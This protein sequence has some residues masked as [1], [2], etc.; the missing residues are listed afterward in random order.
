MT[1]LWFEY[2]DGYRWINGGPVRAWLKRTQR[3]GQASFLLRDPKNMARFAQVQGRLVEVTAERVEDHI[4]RLSHRYT[5][6]LYQWSNENRLIVQIEP[7]R[8][9]GGEF[10]HPGDVEK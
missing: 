3:T 10:R 1:S 5:G 6:Q 4:D 2:A 8:V 7:P 9:A